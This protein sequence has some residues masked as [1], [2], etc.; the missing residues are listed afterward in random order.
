MDKSKLKHMAIVC[1]LAMAVIIVG[2]TGIYQ[3]NKIKA[4][5]NL[6]TTANKYMDSGEYDKAI[7][8]FNQSLG[9]KKDAS[10]ERSIKLAENLKNIK[11]IYDDGMKSINDKRYLEA[12]KKFI[13]VTKEDDR[14]YSSAQKNIAECKSKLIE[15]INESVKNNKFDEANK[16]LDEILK[17]DA[18]NEKVKELKETVVKVVKD[19]QDKAIE[20]EKQQE[21]IKSEEETKQ[22]GTFSKGYLTEQEAITIIKRKFTYKGPNLV[23]SYDHDSQHDGKDFYVIH[24]FENQP[25]HTATLGW[26]AVEKTSGEI[27]DEI[28]NKYVD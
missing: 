17:I 19:Q 24:V 26:Y 18:N 23:Y 8:L 25:T 4:Y 3:Y 13:N 10:I 11:A 16:E 6:I 27:Y 1:I 2:G 5:N 21:K 7:A 22:A 15:I 20:E 14:L 12:I 28:F 9:Y